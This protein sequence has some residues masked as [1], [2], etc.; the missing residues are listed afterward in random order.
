MEQSLLDGIKKN[1]IFKDFEA[2]QIAKILAACKE[3]KLKSQNTLFD[4]GADSGEIYFLIT[5]QLKV[6]ANYSTVSTIRAGGVVGEIGALTNTPRN[7]TIVAV[8]DSQLLWIK[9]ADL[10]SIINEDPD[11]GLKLYKNAV[12]IIAGYLVENKLALEFL[13]AI[14]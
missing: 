12:D 11:L 9:Q 6:I 13:R 5:G 7:A 2:G 8:F 1:K 3:L 10:Q 14:A 4:Q